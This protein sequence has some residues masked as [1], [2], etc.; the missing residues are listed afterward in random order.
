ML[1]KM[2]LRRPADRNL[3][4]VATWP[5]S[6]R[7][8]RKWQSSILPNGRCTQRLHIILPRGNCT[9]WLCGI[10]TNISDTKCP[11]GILP[12][13]KYP[14]WSCGILPRVVAQSGCMTSCK[15]MLHSG[16]AA[17]RQTESAQSRH[18]ASSHWRDAAQ[19]ATGHVAKRY[20]TRWPRGIL[21]TR[22]GTKWQH[23]CC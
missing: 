15:E 10:L 12:N 9:K 17:S 2:A 16:R 22:Y 23:A 19:K 4:K 21:P 1:N 20:F 6:I 5:F 8:C 14:H 13:E 11:P 18:G 7:R 3:H